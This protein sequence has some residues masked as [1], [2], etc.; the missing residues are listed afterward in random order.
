VRGVGGVVEK[1]YA[2]RQA[3]M[4][5]MVLPRENAREIEACPT[6]SRSSR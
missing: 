4:R 1:L 2:A 6:A 3:G 5:A